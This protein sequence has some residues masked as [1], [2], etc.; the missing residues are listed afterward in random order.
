MKKLF[1]CMTEDRLSY[2]IC[3]YHG[4]IFRLYNNG[5]ITKADP[6]DIE[7]ARAFGYIQ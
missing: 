5:R 4:H 6:A 2:A 1:A 3:I 7:A